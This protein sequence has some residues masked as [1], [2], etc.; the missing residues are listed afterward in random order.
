MEAIGTDVLNPN[1]HER[2]W[3]DGTNGVIRNCISSG[4]RRVKNY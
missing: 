2:K 1:K 3:F 4:N